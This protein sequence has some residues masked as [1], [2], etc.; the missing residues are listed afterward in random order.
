MIFLYIHFGMTVYAHYFPFWVNSLQ[1]TY[2][3]FPH[4]KHQWHS[5]KILQFQEY[6]E[7]QRFSL[8]SMASYWWH[9][10]ISIL[11]YSKEEW[12]PVVKRWTYGLLSEAKDGFPVSEWQGERFVVGL[13]KVLCQS[14]FF[15]GIFSGLYNL[16]SVNGMRCILFWIFKNRFNDKVDMKG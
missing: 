12:K 5:N 2:L 6:Q 8:A 14:T 1:L 9:W 11:L 15:S 4:Q 3:N 10:R 7:L 16:L 13:E